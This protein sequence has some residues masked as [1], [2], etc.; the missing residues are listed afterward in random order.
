MEQGGDKRECSDDGCCWDQ[1]NFPF[2]SWDGGGGGEVGNCVDEH[3]GEYVK[4]FLMEGGG[5][6][7]VG[8]MVRLFLFL[9]G[10]F[11]CA[12]ADFL[13]LV[14]GIFAENG[15]GWSGVKLGI[16]RYVWAIIVGEMMKRQWLCCLEVF[17]SIKRRG[18]W[19][20]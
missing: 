3:G 20:V 12:R 14:S 6:K 10:F 4:G 1:T 15:G 2:G 11:S 16:W 19:E 17:L 8:V 7:G 18:G 5:G 9:G 13:P